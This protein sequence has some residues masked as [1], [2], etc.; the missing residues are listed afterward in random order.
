MPVDRGMDNKNVLYVQS[1]N[2]IHLQMKVKFVGKWSDLESLL[3]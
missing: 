1:K 3:R 2:N